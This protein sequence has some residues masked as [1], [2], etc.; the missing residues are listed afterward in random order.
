MKLRECNEDQFERAITD[1]PA[2]KFAKTFLAKARMLNKWENCIGAWD[3]ESLMGAILTT[4]SKRAPKIAN[5][6]LLHTFAEHRR[7]GVARALCI[8]SL[9]WANTIGQAEYFRVS[10][11]PEA[12]PF[13]ESLGMQM[14]G[15]QKSGCSLSM[16]KIQKQGRVSFE[17][18]LYDVNEPTILK[19][20]LRIGKNGKPLKGAVVEFC[21]GKEP[22]SLYLSEII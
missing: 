5:L 17:S 20:T 2:D 13:Y 19:N 16:F 4:V 7:K 9:E 1:D 6:Q 18:G 21:S 14:L 15:K 8:H 3:G 10:S 22:N 11:E 12:V